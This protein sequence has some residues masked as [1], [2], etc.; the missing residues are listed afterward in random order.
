M[1]AYIR[2]HRMK[3]TKDVAEAPVHAASINVNGSWLLSALAIYTKHC[4]VF[5][6]LLSLF[7]HALWEYEIRN[8]ELQ[9][10]KKMEI[11]LHPWVK[12]TSNIDWKSGAIFLSNRFSF[13]QVKS[14]KSDPLWDIWHHFYLE[15]FIWYV[16]FKLSLFAVS[17]YVN[18]SR[19]RKGKQ[20]PVS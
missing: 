12:W 17:Y 16:K 14:I 18:R 10:G 3:S 9:L 1:P 20:L 2:N 8:L 19:S 13:W 4:F 6:V 15:S 7:S 11:T 5:T